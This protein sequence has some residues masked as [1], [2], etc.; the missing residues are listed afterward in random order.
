M[1]YYNRFK[2]SLKGNS[3]DVVIN[4]SVLTVLLDNCTLPKH[5]KDNLA[6]QI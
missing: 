4:I 6:E 2:E 1:D 3:V 5:E